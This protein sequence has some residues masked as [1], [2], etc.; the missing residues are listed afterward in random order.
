[1]DE[2]PAPPATH[3]VSFVP[4]LGIVLSMLSARSLLLLW[5]AVLL[6]VLVGVTSLKRQLLLWPV[7]LMSALVGVT[8]LLL[9]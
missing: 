8:S 7:V 3:R 9:F 5:P 6:S 4:I 1:M 2:K